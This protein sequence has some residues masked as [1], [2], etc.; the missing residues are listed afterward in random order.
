MIYEPV[1]AYSKNIYIIQELSVGVRS[2]EELC[3]VVTERIYD[4]G[5]FLMKED[6][7]LFVRDEFA[8]KDLASDLEEAKGDL[9]AFIKVLLSFRHFMSEDSISEIC[10]GLLDGGDS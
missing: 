4:L 6:L 2:F 10:K 5:D 7:I 1:G 3:F 9:G 8:L